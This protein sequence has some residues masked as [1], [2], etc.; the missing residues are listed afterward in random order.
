MDRLLRVEPEAYVAAMRRELECIL[1]R[2]ME[3]VNDAPDG[4]VISR[5][6]RPVHD[7]MEQLRQRAYEQALQMRLD[8]TEASFSPSGG[9]ADPAAAAEEGKQFAAEVDDQR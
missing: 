3:A 4:Q 2:V 5:S 1:T 8:A 7:L 9:P 6:E